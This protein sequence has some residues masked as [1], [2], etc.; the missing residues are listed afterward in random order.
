MTE[1]KSIII[2][3]EN[4]DTVEVPIEYVDGIFLGGVTE[5]IGLLKLTNNLR[6]FKN[7]E[8]V[9][10]TLDKG[11]ESIECAFGI[12]AAKDRILRYPDITQ[13]GIKS[14]DEE[15]DW[16]FVKWDNLDNDENAFQHTYED[17]YGFSIEIGE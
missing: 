6:T 12:E 8:K 16:Y 4:C 1:V 15:V 2:A 3:F 7:V 13:I 10:I 9:S 17:Q 11:F 14:I 5:S